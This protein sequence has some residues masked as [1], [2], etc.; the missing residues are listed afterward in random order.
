MVRQ[1]DFTPRAAGHA[2]KALRLFPGIGSMSK[3]HALPAAFQQHSHIASLAA[4]LMAEDGIDDY[5][6][7]MAVARQVGGHVVFSF[8]AGD[9][10]V[11][12]GVP[13]SQLGASM[14]DFT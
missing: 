11:L 7:L 14:F 9:S 3:D 10:L 2:Q 8:G 13:L 4:K 12:E 6:D 1:A 5:A